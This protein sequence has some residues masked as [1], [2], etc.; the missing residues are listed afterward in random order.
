M[1]VE[2][3]F[4]SIVDIEFGSAKLKLVD[5][6][7][8]HAAGKGDLVSSRVDHRRNY[9]AECVFR[10]VLECCVAKAT[11]TAVAQSDD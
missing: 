2:A 1:N 4:I 9:W 7:L 11:E 5:L 3:G 6:V 10:C 8:I